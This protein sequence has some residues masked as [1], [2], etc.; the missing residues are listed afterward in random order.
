MRNKKFDRFGGIEKMMDVI[1]YIHHNSYSS[2]AA[3]LRDCKISE[4]GFY[5]HRNYAKKFLRLTIE[6]RKEFQ[7]S[8]HIITN[9]GIINREKLQNNT[10]QYNCIDG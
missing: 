4:S 3:I 7:K 10:E 5:R 1:S 2:T 6:F 8:G 9:Y